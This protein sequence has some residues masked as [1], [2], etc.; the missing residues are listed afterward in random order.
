MWGAGSHCEQIRV[1][2][3]EKDL[4]LGKDCMLSD[5]IEI[6]TSDA[7]TICDKK[8]GEITNRLKGQ[9]IIGDHVWIGRR[10][11][12]TKRANIPSG[13]VVGACSVVTRPFTEENCVIAGFPAKVIKTG[14]EWHEAP[15]W[16]YA[17]QQLAK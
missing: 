10:V 16:L 17:S 13:C 2:V 4:I 1:F 12:L 7:H 8:T 3:Q 14:I 5:N 9:M 11:F 6:M 15:T